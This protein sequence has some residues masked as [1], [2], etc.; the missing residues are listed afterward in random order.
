MTGYLNADIGEECKE[1]LREIAETQERNMTGQLRVMI[2]HFYEKVV[3][4]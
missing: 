3:T 4:E 1:K 2:D